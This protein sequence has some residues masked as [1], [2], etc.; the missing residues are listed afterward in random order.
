M[1]TTMEQR[2]RLIKEIARCQHIQKLYQEIAR[3]QLIQK[4]AQEEQDKQELIQ[5]IACCQLIQ[6]KLAQEEQNK[7]DDQAPAVVDP[8]IVDLPVEPF[9]QPVVVDKRTQELIRK[10]ES[11]FNRL[12]H[13]L[14]VDAVMDTII[15]DNVLWI[16]FHDGTISKSVRIPLPHKTESGLELITNNDVTRVVCDYWLE[17][18]QKR[19]K[20]HDIIET[21]I[22]DD[23]NRIIPHLRSGASFISKIIR[24]FRQDAVAYMVASLQR[25]I[26]NVT[27]NM[28]L[29]E[30][31]MNSWA[32]NHRLMIIDPAFDCIHDPGKQL[33]YQ[34]EKNHKYYE[35]YGWTAI[36]LSDGV[37][38]EKNVILTTNLRDHTPFGYHHNPQRNLYS[39]LSM[40]GDELPRMR[41]KSMQSLIDKGI[42]RKGWNLVTAVLD[43]P[44]NFEDQILVDRSHLSLSHKVQRRYVIY[45]KTLYVKKGEQ[46]ETGT[47]LGV[48]NDGEAVI[49]RMRCDDAYVL[50]IKKTET[51]VGG[52]PVDILVVT[53]EGRRFL[54]DGSKF[55]NLHGNKGIVKFLD[56]GYAV[57]PVT[58]NHIPIDVMVSATS[59]NRRAN[60]GQLL[61]ALAN[62]LTPDDVDHVVLEDDYMIETIKLKTAL[63]NH[64][65]PD[66]GVCVINTYCGEFEAITGKMFWGVTKDPEDQLW[67][68]D[69]PSITN[70]RD[71]RTSG[72]KFS[73]VEMKSLT[74]RFGA[75]NPI[76]TEILSH[77]QGGENLKDEIRI[78]K[79]A[80]GEIEEKYPLLTASSVNF[81][82]TTNGI[83]HELD[84][85][86]GTIVD[87][88]F[89]PDGFILQLPIQV[90]AIVEKDNRD[91]FVIGVPQKVEDT[92]NK[93]IYLYDKIFIPNSM[94]RRCWHHPSG[95]WGLSTI[96]AYV[97]QIVRTTAKF[98]IT[99]DIADH[100]NIIRAV[101]SYFRNVARMMGSKTGEL[102]I[103]SMA[104]RY[105]H[106]SRAT[107][108]L[109]D[110]LPANTIEIHDEM[111]KTLGVK[112]M[113]VVIAERFPCLGFVSIRP[114]YVQVTSDPQCKYVIRSSGNSLCSMNLDFDGDTLFLA[115]FKTPQAIDMLR[116]E[117]LNPNKLCQGEID[118]INARKVPIHREMN[119]DDFEIRTFPKPTGE[120][121]AEIVKKATGVKSH[122][123]PVIALAYNLMRIVET[124]I[125]YNALREHVELELLLDF[126]G[127]TVFSQKHGIKSL[128]EEAT[129]AICTA[130]VEK[131]VELGF[132]RGPSELLCNLIK[133]EAASIGTK[134]LVGYHAFI[135]ENGGS[136]IINKIVRLK[137]RL[138]FATRARLGP[139]KLRDHLRAAPVDLPSYMMRHILTSSLERTSAMMAKRSFDKA[140]K[141]NT[142]ETD[143]IKDLQKQLFVLVDLICGSDNK[144]LQM[145]AEKFTNIGVL[146]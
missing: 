93:E 75:E 16:T 97:N 131:M 48:S 130:D 60:F 125:P 52:E 10:T 136:K 76:A 92:T 83:F 26:N 13:I 1:E 7:L 126:L 80:C 30:T 51:D 29:H 3:C 135:K 23:V 117:M 73:H 85:I 133:K 122:T 81:V 36:G 11:E 84:A 15:L 116:K 43:T 68:E 27:N 94:L 65:M 69:R 127:N 8:P 105:P 44:L 32:M 54:R 5:E 129:D 112:T 79:C 99:G 50:S 107:A 56:L 96:G 95:K 108:A 145:E 62:N 144:N 64:G 47:K 53:V 137:N 28:P 35:L 140:A 46:I 114:Q 6:K 110:S 91:H 24:A 109:S 42:T 20:Y 146:I 38:A 2:N 67:E 59:V 111:A 89:M 66:D 25:L 121:H 21:L 49:M 61:E 78:I 63:H 37:L 39:T 90:Q 104:V 9:P 124:N 106:S 19:L 77:A 12:T 139:F 101:S 103:Y 115:S 118:L 18:E 55:S 72:L 41:T 120:E 113:D 100:I 40:K 87:D 45:G 119:L 57:D 102:S 142:L 143:N 98:L 132:R 31:D 123:G 17:K 14:T 33:E 128:Q 71:L 82:D 4:L 134:D 22:C 141:Q 70:N 58:G 86:K 34:V 74:T 88:E 138:W